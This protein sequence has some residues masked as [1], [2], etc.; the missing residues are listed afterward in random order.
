[1]ELNLTDKKQ[2]SMDIEGDNEHQKHNKPMPKQTTKTN[3]TNEIMPNNRKRKAG[4]DARNKAKQFQNKNIHYRT[5][6]ATEKQKN[7]R[8]KIKRAV[9][10]VKGE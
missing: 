10:E 1:M 9:K 6:Q 5:Q 7:I 3:T 4:Q 2:T 8:N